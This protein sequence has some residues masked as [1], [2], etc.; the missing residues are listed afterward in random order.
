MGKIPDRGSQR[1]SHGYH[2]HHRSDETCWV[3]EQQESRTCPIDQ[4]E[5]R[6]VTCRNS[7]SAVGASEW[8]TPPDME[9]K[10]V[11]LSPRQILS[12]ENKCGLNTHKQKP[13][14]FICF[15][16]IQSPHVSVFKNIL[17]KTIY[18]ILLVWGL[19]LICTQ[20]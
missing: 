7:W 11:P 14:E 16:W 12:T 9:L 10:Y 19:L 20:L 13:R 18:S 5:Q 8:K 15:M 6:R 2:H 17:I 3:F 4:P 1:N